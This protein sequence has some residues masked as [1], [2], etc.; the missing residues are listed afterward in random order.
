[1]VWVLAAGISASP[2]CA[3]ELQQRVLQK[4][5]YVADADS[6]DSEDNCADVRKDCPDVAK[7]FAGDSSW[8]E[9][10]AAVCL[11]SNKSKCVC[12]ADVVYPPLAGND[13]SPAVNAAFK[14]IAEGYACTADTAKTELS[15]RSRSIRGKS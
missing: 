2:I 8:G 12:S 1:M 9:Y 13:G 4:G 7:R 3:E 10:F 11:E 6:K 15:T 5:I 14:K